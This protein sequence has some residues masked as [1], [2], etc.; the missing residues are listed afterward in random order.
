MPSGMR[1]RRRSYSPSDAASSDAATLPRLQLAR[2]AASG[3]EPLLVVADA[4]FDSRQLHLRLALRAL[5]VV[6]RLLSLLDGVLPRA[7]LELVAELG[8][9]LP[10]LA[11]EAADL[12]IDRLE[13]QDQLGSF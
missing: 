5:A 12:Q 4:V 6:L 3:I 8:V 7:H 1:W 2:A 13:I 11:R 9:D 10:N